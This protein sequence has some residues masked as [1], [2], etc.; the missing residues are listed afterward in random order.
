[1]L[2]LIDMRRLLAFIFMIVSLLL[3]ILIPVVNDPDF[4]FYSTMLSLALMLAGYGTLHYYRYGGK[5][6]LSQPGVYVSKYDDIV[7]G[8]REFEYSSIDEIYDVLLTWFQENYYHLESERPFYLKGFYEIPTMGGGSDPRDYSRI[9][10]IMIEEVDDKVRVKIALDSPM[11]L[12]ETQ[13]EKVR[14]IW[15]AVIE[16]LWDYLDKELGNVIYE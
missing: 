2:Y 16:N 13:I 7:T 3:I 15:F 10:R 1:M 4:A 14:P 8:I 5:L 11:V 9:I 12:S 6:S